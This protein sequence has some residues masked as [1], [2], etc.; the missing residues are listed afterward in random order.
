MADRQSQQKSES[1][2][3]CPTTTNPRPVCV[4]LLSK[5]GIKSVRKFN[6]KVF[7]QLQKKQL[8]FGETERLYR[9]KNMLYLYVHI[10]KFQ[11]SINFKPLCITEFQTTA[12]NVK[13]LTIVTCYSLVSK[14]LKGYTD[15][16]KRNIISLAC[17][18]LFKL[19]TNFFTQS[20]E[21][22]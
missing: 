11:Y 13:Q 15:Q 2:S 3:I 21:N 4:L 22:I 8:V 20:K 6:H 12:K 18:Y 19:Y 10:I 16:S 17:F 7:F 5:F 9:A 14:L 1:D